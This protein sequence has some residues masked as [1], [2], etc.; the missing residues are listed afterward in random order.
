MIW[1]YR[2]E[3]WN[4]K[5][6]GR[7]LRGGVESDVQ[8]LAHKTFTIHWIHSIC[9]LKEHVKEMHLKHVIKHTH[10]TPDMIT[11]KPSK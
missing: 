4:Y 3:C 2:Y 11:H 5:W 9:K 8:T 6:K 7:L 1:F 10:L